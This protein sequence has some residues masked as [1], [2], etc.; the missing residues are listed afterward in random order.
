MSASSWRCWRSRSSM[1]DLDDSEVL[2]TEA[3]AAWP[4]ARSGPHRRQLGRQPSDAV[5]ARLGRARPLAHQ[6][7]ALPARDHGSTVA[8]APGAAHRLH[9]GCPGRRHRGRQQLAGLCHPPCAG[10]GAGGAADRRAG[11]ALLAPAPRAADRRDAGAAPAGGAG[12]LARCRQHHAGQGIP[13]R[14]PGDDRRQ[15]CRRP[16]LAAGPL[17]VPRR[18]RRLSALGRRGG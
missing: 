11:Q 8:V 1:A 10:P 13:R 17:S 5:V 18:D 3:L 2:A 15:Q 9:E 4:A 16:A 6:P 12:P 7:H 14:H